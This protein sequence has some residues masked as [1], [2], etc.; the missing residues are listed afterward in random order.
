MKFFGFPVENRLTDLWSIMEFLNPGFLGS[1]HAFRR[2]Y[3]VAIERDLV[4]RADRIVATSTDELFELIRMGGD[5]SRL[6]VIPCGVDLRPVP[7]KCA[8]AL[9]PL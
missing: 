8:G 7:H 3:A 1:E 9:P 6:T 5:G 4:R 2:K